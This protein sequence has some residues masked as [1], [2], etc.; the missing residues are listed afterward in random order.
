MHA[1]NKERYIYF[2]QTHMQYAKEG[3]EEDG[4][5]L[6]SFEQVIS[7]SLSKIHAQL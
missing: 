1:T 3:E 2:V 6:N 7:F 5:I 4:H